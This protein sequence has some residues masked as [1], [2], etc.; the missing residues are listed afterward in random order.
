ML[1]PLLLFLHLRLVAWAE[2]PACTGSGLD[3]SA[4]ARVVL[5][6][7][8]RIAAAPHSRE[9]AEAAMRASGA[10]STRS[11]SLTGIRDPISVASLA[12]QRHEALARGG[13]AS[14]RLQP[15][16]QHP[17]R[18]EQ[19]PQRPGAPVAAPSSARGSDSGSGASA[20][21][22]AAPQQQQPPGAV[23][24]AASAAVLGKG[25]QEAGGGA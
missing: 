13:V 25:A 20:S 16:A 15:P 2:A 9:E 14:E 24:D 3:A 22:D 8:R 4:T 5:L 12:E 10:S 7:V 17:A 18:Q 1:L 6:Q 23:M 11:I 19:R 21:V